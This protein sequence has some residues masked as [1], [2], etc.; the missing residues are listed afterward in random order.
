MVTLS[1][2]GL[3]RHGVLSR[4]MSLTHGQHVLGKNCAGHLFVCPEKRK[5]RWAMLKVSFSFVHTQHVSYRT[6]A[7]GVTLHFLPNVH[8]ASHAW[9]TSSLMRQAH[10]LPLDSG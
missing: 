6:S 2:H 10:R 8:G 4:A 9:D 1:G 5:G 3:P 7:Q